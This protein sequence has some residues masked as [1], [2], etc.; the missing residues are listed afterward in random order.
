[1]STNISTVH[2]YTEHEYASHVEDWIGAKGW[3]LTYW[4]TFINGFTNYVHDAPQGGAANWDLCFGTHLVSKGRM[5]GI[6]ETKS[7]LHF[8]SE[9][10][11]TWIGEP[12][13][14]TG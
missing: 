10:N 12:M 2:R 6:I 1:V 7:L 13:L 9:R 11:R 4:P 3:G 8:A 14:S 5:I